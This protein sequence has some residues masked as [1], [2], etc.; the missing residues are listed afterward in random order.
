VIDLYIAAA[1]IFVFLVGWVGGS[2]TATRQ[3]RFLSD[4]Y[5]KLSDSNMQ[6]QTENR[7]LK[8]EIDELRG[9]IFSLQSQL[10]SYKREVDDLSARLVIMRRDA[11]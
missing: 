8:A 1:V 4:S 9:L 3:T 6:F 2:H 11:N 10:D 5:N 7:K